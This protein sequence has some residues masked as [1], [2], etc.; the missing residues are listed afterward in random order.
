MLDESIDDDS[1][2]T[3]RGKPKLAQKCCRGRK[4]LSERRHLGLP[5][6]TLRE[7]IIVENISA[8]LVVR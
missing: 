7:A 5:I 1:L 6:V 3:K 2:T 8:F 4:P